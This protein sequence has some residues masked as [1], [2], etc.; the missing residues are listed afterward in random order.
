MARPPSPSPT[1]RE[2]EI[3]QVLWEAGEASLSE[4]REVLSRER[5]VAATTVASMLKIMS[6]KG[7]VERTPDRRWRAVVTRDT[8]GKGL[9]DRLLNV[10]FD[11]SAQR[12][13][14]HV[15]ESHPMTRQEVDQLRKLLEDH[16]K[17]S[18]NPKPRR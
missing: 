8:A 12:L 9:L 14:A 4:V 5:P 10:V 11:G 16:Q 18:S 6:D 1:E 17:R 3:L 7:Q 2:L 15:V 13:V